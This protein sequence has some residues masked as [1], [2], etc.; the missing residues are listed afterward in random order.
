[1]GFI[2]C[3]LTQTAVDQSEQVKYKNQMEEIGWFLFDLLILGYVEDPG[4]GVSF[5]VPGGLNWA[6]FIEV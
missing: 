4:T 5:R 2:Q 6:I 3:L 1:M